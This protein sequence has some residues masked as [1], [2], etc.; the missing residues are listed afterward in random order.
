MLSRAASH[1]AAATQPRYDVVIC[2]G[3][4]AGLT[5]ARQ[6]KLELPAVSVAV[7]DRLARPL[8]EAAHKVG[9]A[10]SELAANYF[11]NVLQIEKHLTQRHLL[12]MV[13]RFFLGD[14]R[15]S[16]EH[17][18]EIGP[19]VYPPLPTWQLDR[20]RLE[21]DLRRLVIE[22]G[23]QLLEDT[24]VEDIRLADGDDPHVVLY[25]RNGSQQQERLLGRWVVDA[26][27]RRRMLQS[28]LDIGAANGHSASSAW[29]RIEPR[30]DIGDMTTNADPAWRNRVFGDR[31]MSTNHLMGYGYWVWLI[32]LASGATSVGIVTDET[33]HPIDSYGKSYAQ[34]LQWLQQ[35]EPALWHLLKDRQPLDFHRLKNFSYH[36]RQLFSRTRWS[37][38][39]EAGVFLDPLYS[40]GSDLIAVENTITVEMIA[41]ELRGELTQSE[42]DDFNR[43]VLDLLV[44]I[45]LAYYKDTYR[46]FG[47]PHVFA[48]KLIWDSLI[49]YTVF[50]QVFLQGFV[51]RP[52]REAFDLLRQ[53]KELH[54]RVERLLIDWA[55]A[56]PAR[57]PFTFSDPRQI[58]FIQLVYLE[59]LTR[60]SPEQYLIAAKLNLARLEELAQVFFWQAVEECLP[61][62]IPKDRSKPPWINAWKI[63]LNPERWEADGLY[64][65]WT[66][67]RSLQWMRDEFT[68]T[69]APPTWKQYLRVVLPYRILLLRRGKLAAPL[70]RFLIRL[71]K[72][73]PALWVRRLFV[74]DHPSIPAGATSFHAVGN[75]KHLLSADSHLTH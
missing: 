38:I 3:G 24:A 61:E 31:N 15:G 45:G 19:S 41:R 67:P 50:L 66:K 62:H 72:N 27:G 13:L 29:W 32:P 14:A 20:G 69:F 68:A 7:I 43:L 2:G 4:L 44:P 16:F 73:K 1:P 46:A 6:L 49:N 75:H 37:C 60:R 12:K 5:L 48:A 57:S 74:A 26:L 36:A 59:M 10:T 54:E 17:R 58:R 23:V 47:H 70:T 52:F 56:V 63:S 18:P 53:Y 9:E 35:Y 11:G 25:R 22:N 21:N 8:P 55:Q 34:A 65:P 40:I 39:G 64:G 71:M 51:R 42:V 30:L 28:K 33:I